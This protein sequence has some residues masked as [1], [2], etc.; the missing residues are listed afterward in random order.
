MTWTS[1]QRIEVKR[2]ART[3][4]SAERLTERPRRRRPGEAEHLECRQ[5][6]R[7][8]RELWRAIAAKGRALRQNL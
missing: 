8:V 5:A 4:R 2:S 3:A 6:A 7:S 1:E